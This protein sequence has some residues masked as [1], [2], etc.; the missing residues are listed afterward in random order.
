[1]PQLRPL[2]CFSLLKVIQEEQKQLQLQ[3]MHTLQTYQLNLY[4]QE[5]LHR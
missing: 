2:F 1:M 3:H 5:F 4:L